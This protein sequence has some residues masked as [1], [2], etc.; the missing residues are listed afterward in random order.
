MAWP[1][2]M[3]TTTASDATSC[4][5][6]LTIPNATS[7]ATGVVA[8]FDNRREFERQMRMLSRELEHRRA[9]GQPV[10]PREHYTSLILEPG[11]QRRQRAGIE[12]SRVAVLDSRR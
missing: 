11:D 3:P 1:P 9:K 10:D 12:P 8:A 2:W 7:G 4:A 6:T 5:G